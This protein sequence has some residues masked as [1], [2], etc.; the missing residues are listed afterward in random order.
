V[1]RHKSR[2]LLT[3]DITASAPEE[4]SLLER[5]CWGTDRAL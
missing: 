1:I 4:S 3:D 2:G 5:W